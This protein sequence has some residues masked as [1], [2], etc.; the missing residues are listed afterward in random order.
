MNC[1]VIILAKYHKEWINIVRSFGAKDEAEDIVQEMYLKCDRLNYYDKFINNDKLN[2]P[3]I[4]FMLR[5]LYF[6]YFKQEPYKV[7]I[8]EIKNLSTLESEAENCWNNLNE[9][10]KETTSQ[11]HHY[12][13]LLLDAYF[14]KKTSIRKL[15]KA[16]NISTS[17]LFLDIRQLKTKLNELKENIKHEYYEWEEEE[18][19]A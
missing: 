8:N 13:N 6:D 19:K 11:W 18:S 7:D 3:Y 9:K 14:K 17:S 16:T 5:S 4:F 12:D 2:K 1:K 10:I 15:A